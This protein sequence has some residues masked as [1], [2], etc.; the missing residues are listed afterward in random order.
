M[1]SAR[2]LVGTRRKEE[3][4]SQ[5]RLFCISCHACIFLLPVSCAVT[6]SSMRN[7]RRMCICEIGRAEKPCRLACS[8]HYSPRLM[9]MLHVCARD[10]LPHIIIYFF[11]NCLGRT[12]LG[13]EIRKP[14]QRAQILPPIS[15]LQSQMATTILTLFWTQRSDKCIYIN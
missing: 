4:P 1:N 6:V 15:T 5:L 10:P 7:W 14:S 12:E 13:D 3:L 8:A 11:F 2:A 9:P